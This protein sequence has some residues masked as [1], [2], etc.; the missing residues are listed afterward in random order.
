MAL[1]L[2]V[3][4]PFGLVALAVIASTLPTIEGRE[5]PVIDYLVP[6]LLAAV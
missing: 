5:R 6:G 4:V 3:N 1:D 2:L